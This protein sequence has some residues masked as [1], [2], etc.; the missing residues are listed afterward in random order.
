M[1]HLIITI[2]GNIGAGKSTMAH[3]LAKKLGLKHYSTGGYMREMAKKRGISLMAL[4]EQ[5]EQDNSIDKELDDWQKSLGH[6]EDNFVIDARLGY[7][8]IPHSLK[9]F[10][11]VDEEEGARRIFKEK[12]SDNENLSYEEVLANLKRREKS[13]RERYKKYYGIYFPELDEFDLVIDTTGKTPEE[14]STLVIDWINKKSH[15]I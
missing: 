1:I 6:K 11:K 13:Q 7:R 8:F 10:L 14:V 3:M 12:R 5:A 9:I 2:S 15:L 4:S